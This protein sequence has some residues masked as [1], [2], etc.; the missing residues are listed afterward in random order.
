MER[1]WTSEIWLAEL[2]KLKQRIQ[3]ANH[4]KG[5]EYIKKKSEIQVA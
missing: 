5:Q 1:T 3:A 2:R 4:Q